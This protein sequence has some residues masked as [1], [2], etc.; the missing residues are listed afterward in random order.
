MESVLCSQNDGSGINTLDCKH[1]SIFYVFEHV[2]C[3]DHRN[4]SLENSYLGPEMLDR[5]SVSGPSP[6][7]IRLSSEAYGSWPCW[8][9]PL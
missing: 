3:F 1:D 2:T 7:K 9:S 6:F 4:S 8:G 5:L